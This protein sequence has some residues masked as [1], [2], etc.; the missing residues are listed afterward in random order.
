MTDLRAQ[1]G[2][3]ALEVVEFYE[4]LGGSWEFDAGDVG[5][6]VG[7]WLPQPPGPGARLRIGQQVYFGRG[8]TLDAAVMQARKR[9]TTGG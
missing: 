9:A 3:E 2:G 4:R 7:G 5:V 8:A 1:L 6:S